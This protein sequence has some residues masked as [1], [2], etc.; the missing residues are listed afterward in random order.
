MAIKMAFK[1][2]RPMGKKV[3]SL[4][5]KRT[6]AVP[7]PPVKRAVPVGQPWRTIRGIRGWELE[8]MR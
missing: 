5:D 8:E 1:L 3:S 4:E 6:K 2:K 7:K